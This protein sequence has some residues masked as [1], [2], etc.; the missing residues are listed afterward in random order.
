MNELIETISALSG[1]IKSQ[2]PEAYPE[3]DRDYKNALYKALK[4]RN[5][6]DIYEAYE[7]YE[8]NNNVMP[9]PND[10]A[11]IL[12]D[13]SKATYRGNPI[14]LLKE[15]VQNAGQSSRAE[16][17]KEH[18]ALLSEHYAAGKIAQPERNHNEHMCTKNMCS[19]VGTLSAGL[20]GDG[21]YYCNEH[22]QR[23][24]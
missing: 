23:Q 15:A 17:L 2:Y 19:N 12:P 14:Q 3:N 21:N 9:T 22:Y 10:L 13:I 11:D 18:E 7:L 20:R 1:V 8:V 16:R 5:R 6:D 24:G 4:G